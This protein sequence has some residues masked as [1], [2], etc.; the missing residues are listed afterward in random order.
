MSTELTPSWLIQPEDPNALHSGVWPARTSRDGLGVLNFA[1]VSATE[2]VESYG[3]PLYVMDEAEV[4]ARALEFHSA[5]KAACEPRGVRGEVFYASKSFT[6]GHMVAWLA[7]CGLGFDVATGGEMAVALAGGSRPESIEFQGNNKSVAELKT[8]IN[9][10]IGCIVMDAPIEAHRISA[11]A[12]EAGVIQDV[13]IRVNTGVHA[14]THEYLATARE[15]QKFGLS[16]AETRQLVEHVRDLPGLRCVGLHSHIGS[17]IFALD[18]FLEAATRLVELCAEWADDGDFT[19]LNLGGGFGIAYTEADSPMDITR[20]VKAIVDHTL[21]T[22]DRVG[23]NIRTLAFEP[24]RYISGP[25][26]TTLYSVG[27]VKPVAVSDPATQGTQT[28]TYVS[29]DGGMSDNARTALYGA[30]Y[31]TRIAS[32]V[33]TAEPALV[34]VVGKHCESGDIVVNADFL[35]ADIEPGDVL[36]VAATG[37]YCYSLASNYNVVGRPPVVWVR[38]GQHGVMVSGESIDDVMGRDRGLANSK[39]GE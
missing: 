24:G 30:N 16:A 7:D 39:V 17:Q 2:L 38:D 10:G 35:P 36:A 27:V 31:S 19:T 34:R 6:S 20:M 21:D 33:S 26:G 1:G 15:D 9:A 25:A 11:L 23:A 28:R 4:K 8:A 22:A 18:G 5:V 3:T 14:D 12:V 13:M 37:A 29:V 32:R